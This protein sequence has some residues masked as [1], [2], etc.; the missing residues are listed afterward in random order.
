MS[1]NIKF[2]KTPSKSS[3]LCVIPVDDNLNIKP[4]NKFI[5]YATKTSSFFTG[6]LGQ[7]LFV[8]LP[9]K[10]DFS[11]AVLLGVGALKDLDSLKSEEAGGK[12]FKALKIADVKVASFMD[13]ML[14]AE[15]SAYLAAG[16]HLASYTYTKHKTPPKKQT[17]TDLKTFEII[18]NEQIAIKDFYVPLAHG[19]AG[20]F[21]ARDLINDPPNHL[22]P[23]SFAKII[24]DE[25]SPLGVKVDILDEKKMT[26][27]GMGAIMG[28]GQ[29]SARQP[30]MV[31]MRWNGHPKS[32]D[33][34]VA[35]VG[36]GVTFDTGGISLKPGNGMEEMKMDM[37][38]AAAV[39]GTMKT[40]ALRNARCNVIGAV[41]LAENMASSNAYRPADVLKSYCGKTIEIIN[42]DAEGRLVL[43]DTLSYIQEQYKPKTIIDLA[44]LTGAMMVALGNEYCGVYANDDALWDQMNGASTTTGEKLWRMPLDKVWSD[45]M[46][47]TFADLQNLSKLGR[48]GGANS[49]AS[50]I[51]YFIEDG[52]KWAHMDIAGVA[53]TKS[54][55]PTVPKY[56]TGFGV[57]LLNHWISETYE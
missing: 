25:L 16:L 32:K 55:K 49:A 36:K 29:G 39:V 50:F 52:V 14:T 10:H 46:K 57:R 56:G 6:K 40:L 26:K 24:K 41:G 2:A 12:L 33:T 35:L 19:V 54:A 22:Y 38:G 21:L 8:T 23:E 31:I 9:E 47:G 3:T 17:K 44:T 34:P 27:L 18:S 11:Y 5:D 20:T 45:S 1:L 15:Q 42:T 43:A 30:R 7:T 4:A 53:W 13:D 51:E 37:G 48:W 28:V